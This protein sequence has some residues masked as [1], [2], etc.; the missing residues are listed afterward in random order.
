MIT[1]CL[2]QLAFVAGATIAVA[3]APPAFASQDSHLAGA[4]ADVRAPPQKPA[5]KKPKKKSGLQFVWAPRPSLR[6]SKQT[7]VDFRARLTG[8]TRQSDLST[9]DVSGFDIARRRVGIEGQLFGAVGF[10][11]EREVTNA[12]PWRDVFVD[13]RQFTFARAQAGKF[14]LPFSVDENTGSTN[15]DFAYRS[16]AATTLA[17]GRDRGWMVHGQIFNHALGYEAGMFE[18]DG[19]NAAS[20]SGNRVTGAST[21]AYR[22]TT[23]PFRN[24]KS[25]VSDLELGVAFTSSVLPEG[26]SSIKGQTVLGQ[27]FYKPDYIVSG[28]RRRMGYQLRWRPGPFSVKWEHIRVTEERLGESVEDTALSP[29]LAI[30]WYVSGTWAITGESKSGGLDDPKHPIFNGGAGAMELAIRFE[31]I[32]FSSLAAD[33]APNEDKSTSPRADRVLGNSDEVFTFGVNW[34][35]SRWVKIQ[36]NLLREHLADPS[37]GPMPGQPSFWSRVARVQIGF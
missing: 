7:Y 37:Q 20:T 18:H 17:P 21:Q 1:D 6:W 28:A 24:F 15:M 25:P 22:L 2:R 9:T 32:T 34:Y 31:R 26:R 27:D 16:L 13:Y 30:G 12:D 23:Q 3:T 11:V 35:P 8:E 14:K 10:Q 29:L 36:V 33:A 19:H 5:P 4:H